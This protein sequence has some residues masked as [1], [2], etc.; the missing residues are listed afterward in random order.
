MFTSKKSLNSITHGV[1]VSVVVLRNENNREFLTLER[2]YTEH[3]SPVGPSERKLVEEMAVCEWRQRRVWATETAG[4]DLQ[5]D[6][7]AAEVENKFKRLDEPVRTAFAMKNL[8]DNSS[9]LELMHRYETRFSRQYDR[10]LRRLLEL[11][12]RRNRQPE[13]PQRDKQKL[14]NE[15]GTGPNSGPEPRPSGSGRPVTVLQPR[16]ASPVEPE[17]PGNRPTPHVTMRT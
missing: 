10:A 8:A 6:L 17:S 15:P 14:Q 16:E 7:D 4:I 11:Q 3:Y 12:D 5:M 2:E 13:P 1:F 9:F